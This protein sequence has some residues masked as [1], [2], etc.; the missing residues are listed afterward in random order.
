MEPHTPDSVYDAIIDALIAGDPDRLEDFGRE[1]EGFPDGEDSFLGRRWIT[2]AI[3]VGAL[4][5]I[6]WMLAKNVNLDFED[7]GGYT[8]LHSAIERESTD[9]HVAIE[10]LLRAGA[11]VN[12]RGINGWTPSH[13]AAARDDVDVLEILIRHGADLSIRTSVDEYATPLE[14]ARNLGK[15]RAARYLE[16]FVSSSRPNSP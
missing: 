2:N 16:R 6:E 10:M 5:S 1:I 7:A 15:L 3:D 13:M 8:P 9:R 14:E 4:S 11:P 12:A